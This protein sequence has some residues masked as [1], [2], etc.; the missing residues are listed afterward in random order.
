MV[1]VL[2]GR[3]S[4]TPSPDKVHRDWVAEH[5]LN[6]KKSIYKKWSTYQ[7]AYNSYQ[8]ALDRPGGVQLTE[9]DGTT[10]EVVTKNVFPH[11]STA[12][13]ALFPSHRR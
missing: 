9:R 7:D 1:R 13:T 10:V 6:V 12:Y 3:V 5:C 11:P 8:S 2:L 4:V